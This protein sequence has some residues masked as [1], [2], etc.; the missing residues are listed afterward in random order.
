MSTVRPRRRALAALA[1][2]A[3]F[4]L[5]GC[6]TGFNAQTT[7]QYDAAIGSNSR[8]GD[9][10]VLNALFVAND[11]DTATLSASLLDKA[12]TAT[13]LTDITVTDEKGTE[14]AATFAEPVELK[15]NVLYVSG[16]TPDVMIT[17]AFKLGQFVTASFDFDNAGTVTL[18]VPIV[19]RNGMYDEIAKAPA[20]SAPT[21]TPS[22]TATPTAQ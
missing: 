8:G 17:G 13:S 5:S 11:N 18:K 3:A 6:A 22:A 19:D 4:A 9:V 21:A 10:E 14:I 15:P 7:K 12:R 2:A 1:C 20:K 16:K